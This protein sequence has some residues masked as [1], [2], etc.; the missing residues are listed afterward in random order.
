MKTLA[1]EDPGNLGNL[2]LLPSSFQTGSYGWK[3][4]KRLTIELRDPEGGSDTSEKV[5]VMLT[6]VNP[7]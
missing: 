5:Q 7:L 3:G 4:T 1:S 2:T 6:S